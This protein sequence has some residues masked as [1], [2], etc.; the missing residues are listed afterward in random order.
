MSVDAYL[1]RHLTSPTEDPLDVG[2]SKVGS[3]DLQQPHPLPRFPIFGLDLGVD[4]PS[5]QLLVTL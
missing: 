5:L 3:S 2:E 4:D 1:K